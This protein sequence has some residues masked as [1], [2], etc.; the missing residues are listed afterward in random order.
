LLIA[1]PAFSFVFEGVQLLSVKVPE[2]F[3][4]ETQPAQIEMDEGLPQDCWKGNDRGT[5]LESFGMCSGGEGLVC[6]GRVIAIMLS[7]LGFGRSLP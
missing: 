5:L 2:K 6:G 3:H 4:Q 1:I 7:I